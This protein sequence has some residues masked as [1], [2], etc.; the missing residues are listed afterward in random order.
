M[1]RIEYAYRMRMRPPAIGAVPRE[2][3][4]RVDYREEDTGGR[5]YW[6]RAMYSR[7][8]TGEEL[9]QYEMEPV[10]PDGTGEEISERCMQDGRIEDAGRDSP[11]AGA[12]MDSGGL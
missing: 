12:G 10:D 1:R 4:A 2:G 5:H 11:A 8:L 9:R 7:E 6:G 3:L